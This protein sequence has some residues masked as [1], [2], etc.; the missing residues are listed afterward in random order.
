MISPQKPLVTE[1]MAYCYKQTNGFIWYSTILRWE[2]DHPLAPCG[3][4]FHSG[5][6]T[7]DFQ[8]LLGW[9]HMLCEIFATVHWSE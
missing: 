4:N 3:D 7:L 9:D 5:P 2:E 1:C 6:F 8:L